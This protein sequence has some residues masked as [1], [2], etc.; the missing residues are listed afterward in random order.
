MNAGVFDLIVI[1]KGQAEGSPL[2]IYRGVGS[3]SEGMWGA[4]GRSYARA[5]AFDDMEVWLP[6]RGS[7]EIL[8]N[9]SAI[10]CLAVQ[11]SRDKGSTTDIP[12]H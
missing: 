10:G 3:W 7:G 4:L 5:C 12:A 8:P 11:D 1:K 2:W 9:L 6:R